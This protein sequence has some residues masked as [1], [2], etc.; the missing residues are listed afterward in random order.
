MIHRYNG[1]DPQQRA[2]GIT[3]AVAAARRGE[4]VVANLDGSYAVITDAF[5]HKGVEAINA[6]KGRTGMTIP[7]L[8]GKPDTVDGVALLQGESGVLARTLMR[9]CW[10][11]P[12]TIIGTAQPSLPWKCSPDG[13]VPV[14]MPMHPWTLE[15]V[16]ALGP[17]ANVPT[18]AP[19]EEPHGSVEAVE[20]TLGEA[21]SV[22]LD[23]GPCL[24]DQT[25][26]IIDVT[27]AQAVI[28]RA[29]A[30]TIDYL[31]TLVPLAE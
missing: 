29:G 6:L 23:G 30:F 16:R 24:P 17:T 28:T 15:L 27:G 18:H 20:A 22:Y 19:G 1:S 31:A 5:S 10:P 7:V 2:E 14:R 25:S 8:V 11:G 3:H 4:L 13:V 26:T 9:D 21:V 12:L